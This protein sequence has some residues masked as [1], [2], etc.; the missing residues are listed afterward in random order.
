M[1]QPLPPAPPHPRPDDM[2]P[3][4]AP[5]TTPRLWAGHVHPRGAPQSPSLRVIHSHNLGESSLLILP[6]PGRMPT[7][8]EAGERRGESSRWGVPPLGLRD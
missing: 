7:A 3:G 5:P 6:H 1:N 8:Q 4:L 2:A